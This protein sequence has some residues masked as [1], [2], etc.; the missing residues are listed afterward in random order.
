[1]QK[2]EQIGLIPKSSPFLLDCFHMIVKYRYVGL[3][4]DYSEPFVHSGQSIIP[5]PSQVEQVV[6][7]SS[8]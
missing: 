6:S 5:V 4:R 3:M 2:G 1:M 7:P 8:Q